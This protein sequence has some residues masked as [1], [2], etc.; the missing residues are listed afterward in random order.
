MNAFLRGLLLILS[1]WLGTAGTCF[2][3]QVYLRDGSIV[4]C[5]SFW[6]QGDKVMVKVNR[7]IVVDFQRAEVNMARTF[8]AARKK[9][10]HGA[11]KAVAGTKHAPVIEQVQIAKAEAGPET[12]AK[13]KAAPAPQA[14]PLPPAAPAP[15]P[16]APQAAPAQPEPAQQVAADPSSPPGKEEMDSKRK[17]AAEMMAEAIKKKDPE[18]L[19]KA[20]D[21]QKGLMPPQEREK[22]EGMSRAYLIVWLLVAILIIASM[23]ITFE[24]AGQAGWKSLIPIYNIYILLVMADKP[25]WWL[26]LLLIPLV[27]FVFYL[28]AMLELARKFGKEAIFGVGLCLVPMVF[29]PLLAFGSAQYEG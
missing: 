27:G 26:L 17:E 24:K 10:H 4:D 1:L 19:K 25:G 18:L 9:A 21:A 23:W 8:P 15:V 13:P 14:K 20:I 11:H 6:R 12:A 22:M 2:G 5:Q 28:L 7:D 3:K 29:F 16:A